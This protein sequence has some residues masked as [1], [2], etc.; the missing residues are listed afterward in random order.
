[1]LAEILGSSALLVSRQGRAQP[2]VLVNAT[3]YEQFSIASIPTSALFTKSADEPNRCANSALSRTESPRNGDQP[4]TQR[5]SQNVPRPGP[6]RPPAA[7]PV[8]YVPRRDFFPDWK[9]GR[10][11]QN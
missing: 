6:A 3:K 9:P 7:R 2:P 4:F 5:M 11:E 10:A 8:L 1:M